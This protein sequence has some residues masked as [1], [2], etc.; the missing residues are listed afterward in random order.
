[1]RKKIALLLL[2]PFLS[3]CLASPTQ[4]EPASDDNQISSNDS[5]NQNDD[6]TDQNGEGTLSENNDDSGTE[7]NQDDSND[8]NQNQDNTGEDDN[9]DVSGNQNQD[10]TGEDNNNEDPVNT[11]TYTDLGLKTIAEARELCTQYVT[12]L[13][14]AGIGVDFSKKVTIRG[15]AAQKF[16]LVKTKKS[17]GLDVSAPAKVLFMDST[18]YICSASQGGSEGT[19]LF[20]KVGSY[21]GTAD[22]YYEFSGY[23]SIYLGKPEIY[24]PDK[25]FSWNKD[26]EV[27]YSYTSL[28]KETIDIDG[29]YNYAKN[30]NYNCAGHG[31]GDIYKLENLLCVAKDDTVYVFT[32]GSN[33]L[34]VVNNKSTIIVGKTYDLI[35]TLSLQ[36]YFPAIRLLQIEQKSNDLVVD[37]ASGA[38][39][40]TITNFKKTDA[41]QEDTNKRYPEFIESFKKLRKS[42]VFASYY[43]TNGKYYVTVGDNYYTGNNEI[44]SEDTAV[45]T[46][47][48]VALENNNCWNAY[49][50]DVERYCPIPY[51][52]DNQSF[53]IYYL[54]WQTHY[55]NKKV[56]W[57]IYAIEELLP[58]D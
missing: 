16:D 4:E 51:I 24:V 5:N 9:G 25:S 39:E 54:P 56:A 23:L 12:N 8:D 32:D 19:S 30:N 33:Y 10:N 50:D 14:S 36:N 2:I 48:M 46:H 15:F 47:Q 37:L 31:Y 21:A 27:N 35:G 11:P 41:S 13:N 40:T 55:V 34:R 7:Q 52:N 22:S 44:T 6:S 43:T 1:M 49:W 20:G 38:L 58:H 17:F 53:D 57:K 45:N 28:V 3:A 18:G 42:T 26:L 29:F